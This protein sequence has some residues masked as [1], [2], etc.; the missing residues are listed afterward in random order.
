MPEQTTTNLAK[1]TKKPSGLPPEIDRVLPGYKPS[2]DQPK[3]KEI[4]NAVNSLYKEAAKGNPNTFDYAGYA[5]N[6]KL[7]EKS[8]NALVTSPAQTKEFAG[9]TPP[10]RN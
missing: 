5:N 8:F 2:N 6:L 4:I 10:R 7:A 3:G 1:T 9:S